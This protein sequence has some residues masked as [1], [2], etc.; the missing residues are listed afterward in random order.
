MVSTLQPLYFQPGFLVSQGILVLAF[1]GS[2]FWRR[3]RTLFAADQGRVKRQSELQAVDGFLAQMDRAAAQRDA[4]TFFLSARQALQHCLAWR[5]NM[6][7]AAITGAELDAH[8]NG[9]GEN[10]RNVFALA[11][12]LAY[13]A[14]ESIDTDFATWRKTVHQL[15][16]QA[17]TL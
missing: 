8:L 10:F 13:S 3:Q 9:G 4:A 5:W 1:I 17:E 6:A 14:G 15:V 7:P 11:D 12:Q 16:K 2:G